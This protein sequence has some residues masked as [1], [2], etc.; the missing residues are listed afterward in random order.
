MSQDTQSALSNGKTRGTSIA[1]STTNTRHKQVRRRV[2]VMLRARYPLQVA[3]L[4]ASECATKYQKIV[5]DMNLSTSRHRYPPVVQC[6]NP[7]S[8]LQ[9]DDCRCLFRVAH[10][11]ALMQPASDFPRKHAR[12]HPNIPKKDA[13]PGWILMFACF[14]LAICSTL[15][16]IMLIDELT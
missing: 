5:C 2:F 6:V 7:H 14:V 1:T 9:F 16:R 4:H 15:V 11:A 12:A 8:Y 13:C 3:A 10:F